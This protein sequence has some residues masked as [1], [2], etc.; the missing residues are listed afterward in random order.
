MC[1]CL[2]FANHERSA[3]SSATKNKKS[4]EKERLREKEWRAR[5]QLCVFGLNAI[6]VCGP[7]AIFTL[8]FPLLLIVTALL[9]GGRK[10]GRTSSR[11]TRV[12]DGSFGRTLQ[13]LRDAASV[14]AFPLK[15]AGCEKAK[16]HTCMATESKHIP[17]L[18]I[19]FLLLVVSS[20]FRRLYGG[21]TCVW[22]VASNGRFF[23][24]RLKRANR[25]RVDILVDHCNLCTY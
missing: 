17:G 2:S 12:S 23:F 16:V 6:L 1:L 5:R 13:V 21:P 22:W 20:C 18:A 4:D 3:L 7:K 11:F 9:M 15:T 8:S 24:E 10:G 14:L 19:A 25:Y